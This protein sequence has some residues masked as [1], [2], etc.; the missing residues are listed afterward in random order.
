[1][2]VSCSAGTSPSSPLHVDNKESTTC[3]A[4][5]RDTVSRD[6]N[7]NRREITPTG[8]VSWST[9]PLYGAGGFSSPPPPPPT[10]TTCDLVAASLTRGA[11]SVTYWPTSVGDPPPPGPS[12][13][14]TQTITASYTGDFIHPVSLS[15]SQPIGTQPTG[16]YVADQHSITVSAACSP[17]SSR[18]Q[19]LILGGA[20]VATT[21]CTVTVVDTAT[22]GVPV[23]PT[24]TVAWTVTSGGA[25]GTGSFTSTP[26]TLQPVSSTTA[27]CVVTYQPTAMG[28]ADGTDQVNTH[29]L[30][31]TYA[32]DGLHP[33]VNNTDS[34]NVYVANI[35]LVSVS[36]VNCTPLTSATAP[37]VVGPPATTTACSVTVT[38]TSG[39]P[40]TPT[41]SVTWSMN[42]IGAGGAGTFTPN[43]PCTLQAVNASTAQCAAPVVYQPTVVGTPDGSGGATNPGD[44]THVLIATYSTDGLH[45]AFGGD[46]VGQFPISVD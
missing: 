16:I 14:D 24:N 7:N 30:T 41:G 35:H 8:T 42:S 44:N 3:T 11:C 20:S 26:C 5:V 17:Q 43:T 2:A 4:T 9:S 31:A 21:Q 40:V 27:N 18:A 6:A 10:T 45:Q 25:G 37:L 12:F 33:P 39:A 36:I 19:P 32:G 1:V 28:A 13:L 29:I 15:G 38:D 22:L 34:T 46:Q 23:T